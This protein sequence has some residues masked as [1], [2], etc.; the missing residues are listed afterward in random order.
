MVLKNTWFMNR[1]G[2]WNGSFLYYFNEFC[3]EDVIFISNLI[4]RISQDHATE[5]L[6]LTRLT[7]F[8]SRRPAKSC[9]FVSRNTIIF[10]QSR[11]SCEMHGS[12]N[13]PQQF[14]PIH[15]LWRRKDSKTRSTLGLVDKVSAPSISSVYHWYLSSKISKITRIGSENGFVIN[16]IDLN[17]VYHRIL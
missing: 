7:G 6:Y 14:R 13:Q 17:F 15:G 16:L 11:A 10:A 1:W 8:P 2:T 3:D 5:I 12:R 4:D 9:R